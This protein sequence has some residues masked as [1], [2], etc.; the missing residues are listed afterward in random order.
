M[1]LTLLVLLAAA[2]VLPLGAQ[3]EG[4]RG[5]D[6]QFQASGLKP[7]SAFPVAQI[8]DAEGK[9]YNTS[10]LKGFVTVVVNGCLT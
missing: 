5:P 4:R 7:G 1:R 9:A 3:P 10:S 8:Y 2:A 6:A